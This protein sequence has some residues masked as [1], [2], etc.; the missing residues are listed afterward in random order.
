MIDNTMHDEIKYQGKPLT[1]D[2]SYLPGYGRA[3]ETMALRPGGREVECVRSATLEEAQRVHRLMLA[4]YTAEPGEPEQPA[5]LTGKYAK[6]RDDLRTA[7]AATEPLEQTEDG[8]TC[9]FDSPALFL[10]R[11]NGKLIEQAA[12]EAG[13]GAWKWTLWGSSRWV[14]SFRSTGQANRRS[15]R[16]EALVKELTRMGYDCTE[17]CQAD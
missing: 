17:Y 9:N 2:T 4:K 12:K 13:C 6:L 8:G 14:I 7:L 5:P 11:W 15:R 3:Y 16:A 1:V 10:P